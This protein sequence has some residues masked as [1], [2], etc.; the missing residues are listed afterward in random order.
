MKWCRYQAENATSFGLLEGDQVVVVRG[1]PFT[2]HEITTAK[3]PLV[4]VTLLPPIVPPV[5]YVAGPNHKRHIDEMAK[6][7]GKAP[8]YPTFPEANFRS[9]HALVAT[10]QPIIVPTG[11][12]GKLQPEGQLVVII[13]KKARNVAR[14][15]ARNHIF[16]LSIGNDI[17]ERAWQAADR[18]KNT[19]T[20]LPFGPCIATGLDPDNRRIV[21]RHNGRVW[22]DF[23]SSEQIFDAATW[24]SELSRYTTLHPGDA[25]FMGTQ[26]SDGDMVAGDV[27]EV[28]IE[29]VGVLRNK[30]VAET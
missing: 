10:N 9:V 19:D 24:I 3:R 26:G 23:N 4:D 7:R 22:Q 27:I 13:G 6:R 28:E 20:F 5:I 2:G 21:V 17:T 29:G 18:T 25:I 16:G 11:S 8:V 12:A 15:D 30:L 14:A 1:D